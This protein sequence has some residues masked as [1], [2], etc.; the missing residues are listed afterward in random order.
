MAEIIED[1]KIGGFADYN[2]RTFRGGNINRASLKELPVIDVGPFVKSSL[3]AER[4]SAAGQLRE[5]CIDIGFFYITGHGIAQSE[6][7]EAI[8]WGHRLFGLSL[9]D[10]LSLGL[11]GRNVSGGYVRLGGNNPESVAKKSDIKE[12]Y[13]MARDAIPGE[14][15]EGNFAAG[16]MSWPDHSE[17]AGFTDFM[18]THYEKRINLA[19]QVVRAF[20]LSLDL[21]ERYFDDMYRYLGATMLFN[22]Y[23]SL[24]PGEVAKNQWSFSPHTDYG[25]FTILAQDGTGGLQ[26]RNSDGEWI[27]VPPLDGTFVINIGDMFSMWTNDLYAS[28]LHRAMNYA[29]A[30]RISM[31]MFTYPQGRTRISCLATCQGPEN[32]PRYQPVIAEDYNNLLIA[33]SHRTGRPGISSGTA[34]RFESV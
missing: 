34:E 24:T 3:F 1:G 10:K 21:D 28:S 22:F 13:F 27:D 16:T 5:A 30:P 7:D 8:E 17:L 9:E 23:P 20:A 19:R 26:A 12:R 14:P 6:I 11:Y 33:Q 29:G 32:P 15:T 25:M 18:K 4:Q 31:P 2:N